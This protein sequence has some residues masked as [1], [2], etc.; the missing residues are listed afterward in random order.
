MGIWWKVPDDVR[1]SSYACQVTVPESGLAPATYY[2]TCGFHC[3]YCGIQ[4]HSGGKKQLLFS[5]WD[6]P[7]CENCASLDSGECSANRFGGEG[8]GAGNY[9]T[10]E[11]AIFANWTPGTVYTF[12]VRARGEPDSGIT[13]LTCHVFTPE[14]CE[15][16]GLGSV[17]RPQ[18]PGDE[19]VLKGL[20]SFIEEFGGIKGTSKSGLWGPA[21]YQRIGGDEWESVIG[22][23]TTSTVNPNILPNQ[24]ASLAECGS[25]VCLETGG[26]ALDNPGPFSGTL[27]TAEPAPELALLPP[28]DM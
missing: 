20:Y 17:W 16:H 22:A 4:E 23:K 13:L 2:M 7:G 21:W 19:G 8:C 24:R 26:N 14:D 11:E 6:S 1:V 18:E 27:K 25:R 9:I 15:W 10:N 3:G 28:W 5:V 12:C